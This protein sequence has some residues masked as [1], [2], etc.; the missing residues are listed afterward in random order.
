MVNKKKALVICS[1][2]L[3]MFA[4]V[5]ADVF[6]SKHHEAKKRATKAQFHGTLLDVPRPVKAFALTGTDGTPFNQTSLRDQ[7]T[8]IFFGFTHCGLVCPTTMAELGKMYR[9]LEEKHVSPLPRVVMVSIDPARDDLAGLRK[10]VTAF[11]PNFYGARGSEKMTKAMT[12]ALGI[13]YAK[14][15]ANPHAPAPGDDIEH[16]GAIMLFNP[17]GK[18]AAFFTGPHQAKALGD[19][20]DW[21]MKHPH[22]ASE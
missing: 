17:M 6:Y 11:N 12:S 4:G 19:D 18:L 2:L 22:I 9:L 21:L 8:M 16:T 7:W 13:A 1:A 14:V 15:A 5:I 10:Y 3:L 20:Y